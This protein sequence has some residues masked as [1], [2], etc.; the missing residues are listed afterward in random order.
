MG[1]RK[2][3][4]KPDKMLGASS[5]KELRYVEHFGLREMHF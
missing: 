2:W 4:A 3:L 1:T 5:I